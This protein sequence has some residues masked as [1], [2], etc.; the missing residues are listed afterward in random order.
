MTVHSRTATVQLSPFSVASSAKMIGKNNESS[1]YMALW[2]TKANCHGRVV[3]SSGSLVRTQRSSIGT[4]HRSAMKLKKNPWAALFP[5]PVVLVTC[6]DSDGK[7]NIITLA[8]SGV[9]CSEPPTIG[10]GIR[11]ERHSYRLI[12]D[13]A[14]F[15]ANIP[16]KDML[17]A[18]DFCGVVSGR[19]VDKFSETGL[20]PEP[21]E[22]VKPPLIREC[23]VNMECL[24]SKK[25]AVG[26]HH[27]FLG[28]IIRVHVDEEALD[29][30]GRIDFRKVSPF[31]YN[32]GEYWDLHER[33]GVHGFSKQPATGN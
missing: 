13:S 7:P 2:S 11:P 18:V 19:D 16:T 20:T 10:L 26:T 25:I 22:K 21:A 33:I 23:P 27:L 17:K 5:C 14:E 15:V 9:V 3:S 6:V 8:W 30:T 28:E 24:L 12:E 29:K 31:V 4:T 32:Q 1:G